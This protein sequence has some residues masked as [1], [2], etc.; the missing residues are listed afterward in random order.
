[1]KMK[2]H[3]VFICITVV[4]LFVGKDHRIFFVQFLLKMFQLIIHVHTSSLL[5]YL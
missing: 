4:Q 5:I 2:L 1:M 3:P